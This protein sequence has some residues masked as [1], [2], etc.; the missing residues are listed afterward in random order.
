MTLWKQL[1]AII[2][3]SVLVAGCSVL[4]PAQ[5]GG[6]QA[7][8]TVEAVEV[9]I[10]PQTSGRV[11][12]VFVSEGDNVA[13]GDPLF[14]LEDDLLNAQRRVAQA[15]LDAAQANLE[16]AR[17]AVP[18]TQAALDSATQAVQSAQIQYEIILSAARQA[19]EP[20]RVQSW[21][22]TVPREF[23]QPA[24]Y[25][26]QA[27]H[28]QAAQN[29]VDAA[30]Q[31]LRV[32]QANFDRVIA[33]ASNANLQAAEKRLADAQ[34]A[35]LVAQALTDRP[36][37]R[38]D[39]DLEQSA[40]SRLDSAK[41][42]L[43]AAQQA[44]DQLLSEQASK[45]VLEA[46]ARLAVAQERYNTA[47]DQLDALQTGE[48][49]LQVAAAQASV[50]QAQAGV[51]QAQATL[52]QAQQAVDLAN[53]G[54]A[55]AQAQLDLVDL[56]IEKLIVH[57]AVSGVVLTR[58]LQPGETIA[59]GS[60][61]LTIGELDHLTITVYIPEDQYGQIKLGETAQ[62]AVDSYPGQVFN[63]SVTRIADQA[64]YTPR[65]VQTVAGRKTTVF[66]ID[67]TVDNP[68]GKLK[69]G[70]PADV[71]FGSS[72]LQPTSSSSFQLP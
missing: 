36:G 28:L 9:N 40:Q 72:G 44:Y 12:E 71:G 37:V 17:V 48:D 51:A 56:Q 15:G 29:E 64:E 66:A 6:I 7:S 33:D 31:D 32:E 23:S 70:M 10:A 30:Q 62:V 50:A 18:V 34:S 5:S 55:Q 2:L 43:D 65:S 46:R 3:T 59:A 20:Q 25:F 57:S 19:A 67:L 26:N 54:V 24:W 60:Q 35:F 16:S 61:A 41:T 69:P 45:D 14:R 42:E 53:T 38:Q 68:D 4:S 13:V 8:G 47:Q 27:E 39:K 58:N 21:D 22:R 11:A 1:I 63:A 49:S 52:N